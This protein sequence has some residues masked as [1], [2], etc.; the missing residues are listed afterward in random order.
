MLT[1]TWI[2]LLVGVIPECF[3][4][5]F[6]VYKLT[7]KPICIK[8]L[9]LSTI[10]MTLTTYMIRLLPIQFG[11]HTL[12]II[13]IFILVSIYIN[14]LETVKAITSILF[15]FIIRLISEW[16]MFFVLKE[17]FNISTED[18]FD[19]PEKKV[20]YTLPSLFM[21]FAMIIMAHYIKYKKW[22][23]R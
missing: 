20:I 2:E 4:F 22:R 15:L 18:L 13:V 5:V 7:N 16:F 8:S 10:L 19:N 12:I 17:A 1:L 11:V 6:G 3:V 9:L 21:F 14:K 23:K